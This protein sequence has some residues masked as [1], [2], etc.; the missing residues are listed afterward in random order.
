V[1]QNCPNHV[2]ASSLWT[3]SGDRCG[4]GA[5]RPYRTSLAPPP[6]ETAAWRG[7]GES[8]RL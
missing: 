7:S 4:P 5:A 2:L 1:G 3:F 8:E 6:T